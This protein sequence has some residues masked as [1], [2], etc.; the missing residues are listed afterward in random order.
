MIQPMRRVPMSSYWITPSPCSRPSFV[1][2]TRSLKKRYY[3]LRGHN[4]RSN[5]L[6]ILH[7]FQGEI[8]NKDPFP[9]EE[10]CPC[11]T[12]ILCR[13]PVASA[14]VSKYSL[15][16]PVTTLKFI[17]LCKRLRESRLRPPS[18]HGASSPNILL[19]ILYN[20]PSERESRPA[21]GHNMPEA[22]WELM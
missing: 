13:W 2:S 5:R 16:V 12:N 8:S 11:I 22:F 17:F 7:C 15:A 18:G 6:T 4:V 19:T 1:C 21:C 3:E 10:L 9:W 14:Y 20:T